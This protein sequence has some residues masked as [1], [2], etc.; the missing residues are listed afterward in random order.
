MI[1]CPYIRDGFVKNRTLILERAISGPVQKPEP[2]PPCYKNGLSGYEKSLC[3]SEDGRRL[4]VGVLTNPRSGGNKKG[5]SEI[6]SILAQWPDVLHHE[7]FTP[8]GMNE[9]LADFARNGVELVIINGGDGT[10]HATLTAIGRGEIFA[11]PPLL[12]LL[13]AGTT[14]M[15]PRDVGVPGSAASALSRI[16]RWAKSTDKSLA[17]LP[18]PVLQVQQASKQPA[19][20]GMFFGAG[21]ICQ[22]IKLFHSG[23]NPMGW[24]GEL[25][26]GLTLLRM[27]LAILCRDH[28]KV[29]P[30]LTKTSLNGQPPQERKDLF[31]LVSTLERLFL[32]MRPYWGTEDGPLYYTAVG[33]E[34]KR[35][36]RVLP[37]L[38]RG[39]KNR[40]TA[41]ENGYFSHNLHEVQLEMD[42]GF[43]LDGELYSAEQEVV[44]IRATDPVMFLCP[45]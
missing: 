3:S 22:G 11:K 6:R 29:P 15:L 42:G 2:A 41:P 23:V 34:S 30:L 27:M 43:T 20:F 18:R 13:C 39:R 16:L 17:V 4:Q 32:G 38:A 40:Y 21:A 19:L 5:L 44:T 28:R 25:M 12:A 7:E 33:T 8:A 26:P 9:A 45:S 31:V 14:S 36:L 24:R 1:S 10:A 35:L 37:S